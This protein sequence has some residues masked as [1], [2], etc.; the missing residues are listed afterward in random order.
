[1]KNKDE[2]KPALLSIIVMISIIIGF[3]VL[4]ITALFSPM[5][6]DEISGNTQ[7]YDSDYTPFSFIYVVFILIAAFLILDKLNKKFKRK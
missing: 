4:I 1:M 3:I 5:S 6:I 2:K 7:N